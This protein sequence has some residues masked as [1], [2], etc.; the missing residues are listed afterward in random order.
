M[1]NR[2]EKSGYARREADP[3]DR[4]RVRVVMEDSAQARI[5]RVYGPMYERFGRLFADYTPDE[6]AVLADWFTR[7]K[8]LLRESLD[9]IREG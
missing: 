5:L 7:A 1:L 6:I 2:L 9:E 8:A 4:R 3:A